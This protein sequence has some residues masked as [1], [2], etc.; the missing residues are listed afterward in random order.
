[1]SKYYVNK[2]KNHEVHKMSCSYLPEQGN[3]IEIEAMND[4]DAM[5]QA[6]DYYYSDANGCALCINEYHTIYRTSFFSCQ[7]EKFHYSAEKYR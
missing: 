6:R 4:F 3:R 2:G 7:D 5:S 1:M